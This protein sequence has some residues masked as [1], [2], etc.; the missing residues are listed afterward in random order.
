LCSCQ[1]KWKD[2]IINWAWGT[3]LGSGDILDLDD[4]LFWTS[5]IKHGSDETFWMNDCREEKGS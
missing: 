1:P 2:L 3:I 5:I 4:R